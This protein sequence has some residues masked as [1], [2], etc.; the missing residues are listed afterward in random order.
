MEK[1]N[2]AS[3]DAG[4]SKMALMAAKKNYSLVEKNINKT[5]LG[6][7]DMFVSIATIAEKARLQFTPVGMLQSYVV[8]PKLK[9]QG[10]IEITSLDK[11]K[12]AQVDY[13]MW[14]NKYRE[15]FVD[16]VPNG[17]Q[18]N[19]TCTKCGEPLQA[20][21]KG[22]IKQHHFAQKGYNKFI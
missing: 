2:V 7:L 15:E 12:K 16:D 22:I 18:C 17:K 13:T 6:F 4:S 19:C 10:T 11:L 1:M 14:S 5:G 3:E 9:E 8:E 21:N 20:K